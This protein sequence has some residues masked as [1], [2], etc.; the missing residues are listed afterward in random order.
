MEDGIEHED[1][2]RNL[3]QLMT[4]NEVEQ[5]GLYK[6]DDHKHF[7]P[8][9]DIPPSGILEIKYQIPSVHVEQVV[10]GKIPGNYNKQIQ[11]GLF[12][13]ERKWCDYTSY[14][15]TVK[16]KPM[17]RKRVGRDEELIKTLNEGADKFLAELAQVIRNFKES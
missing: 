7:S 5:V 2:A 10:S 13:C 1:E 16:D 11:W 8:D 12:I 14:S 4:G 6:L 15:P 9:G 3:Y 17:W